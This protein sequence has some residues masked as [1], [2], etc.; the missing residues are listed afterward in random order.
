MDNDTRTLLNLTDP[1]LNFPHHWLNYR[2]SSFFNGRV[3]S[4]H[5]EVFMYIVAP[6]IYFEGLNFKN[7]LATGLK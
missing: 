5:T 1:H 4:F 2:T 6:L 7:K 3:A